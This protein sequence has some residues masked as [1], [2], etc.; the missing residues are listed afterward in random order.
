M[1]YREA[2][3]RT[4][5]GEP[6]DRLVW[7]PRIY[8]WYYGNN[9]PNEPPEDY[10]RAGREPLSIHVEHVS[11]PQVPDEFRTQRMIDLYRKLPASPRYPQE[12]LR[13]RLFEIRYDRTVRVH[14]EESDGRVVTVFETP[15]G[16]LRQVSEHHYQVEHLLKGPPDFKVMAYVL[17]HS[18]FVF[19]QDA[20]E[21]A[22]REFGDLGVVT[23]FY[24]RTPLQRLIVELMGFE[25]VVYALTDYPRETE[26]LMRVIESWDDRM[27]EVLLASP[28][29]ILNFGENLDANV[30]PPPWFEKYLAPYYE[31][32]IAQIHAAGKFCHI[33]IDG[34]MKPIIPYIRQLQFDAI[35]AATPLPQGDVT[36]EEMK[37]A[38]EGKILLDGI[39]AIL[40]LPS[41]PQDDFEEFVH[42]VIDLFWPKLILGVSDEL[43]PGGDIRRV[44]WVSDF[45]EH[46]T[47]PQR[48]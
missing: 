30:D 24:P 45:V 36:L 33:H 16:E 32:R 27:Y 38:L 43:P 10:L 14:T 25:N 17:D 42:K 44:K 21:I 2:I 15:V 34:A 31:K 41:Y 26:E 18:E 13:V 5:R 47:P 11:N 4:F 6:V 35:E 46:W 37:E 28:I 22:D 3:L 39:P 12:T 23:T 20:F 19:W 9:L 48:A 29:Q 7:Q 40:F 1:T 8:Y